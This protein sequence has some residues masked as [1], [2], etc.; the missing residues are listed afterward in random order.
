MSANVEKGMKI[1]VKIGKTYVDNDKYMEK[2]RHKDKNVGYAGECQRMSENVGKC[3]YTPGWQ[4]L[5]KGTKGLCQQIWTKI[6][7]L[8]CATLSRY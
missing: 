1:I 7:A 4:K 5:C 3:R 6:Q 2:D 8:T